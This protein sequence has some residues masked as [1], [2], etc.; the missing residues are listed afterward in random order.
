MSDGGQGWDA[1]IIITRSMPAL[2]PPSDLL[3]VELFKTEFPKSTLWNFL[4]VRAR[5]SRTRALYSLSCRVGN[6][7]TH[8]LSLNL[9]SQLHLCL[10]LTAH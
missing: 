5:D 7:L 3:V 4:F 2:A 10:S 8:A 6:T 1:Q 9:R